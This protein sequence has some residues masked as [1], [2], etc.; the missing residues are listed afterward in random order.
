[1]T[2]KKT[3]LLL[4]IAAFI[5][6]S[7]VTTLSQATYAV[8][9]SDWKA[10]NIIDD[11]L[12]TYA[13]AMNVAQIQTFLN[14]M[15]GT[16]TNGVPGQC[17][18]NGTRTSEYGGGT[19]AEYAAN[20]SLHPRTGAFYPPFTC[21]KD[22][23]EVPKTVPGPGIPAN[24][25]GGKPIPAGAKSAAQLIWDAAQKY[26]ISP[27]VLLVKLGTESAGPL[28][29]D[30]WPTLSQYTYAMGSHCPDSGPDGS[31]NCNTDYSGFSIQISSAASLLRYY[32][33][34]MTAPWW[35]YTKPYQ[36]NSI[37]WNIVE[38]GCG[39][40]NVLVDNKAT[41]ALYTYTPYQPN[42]AAL[43]NMYGNGDSC[44]AY[45]NRNF[46][47]TYNDWFGVT[48]NPSMQFSVIQD[49]NSSTLYLQTS[50]GKYYFSSDAMVQTW[51]LGT[52][53][54]VQVSKAYFDSFTTIG[55][56]SRLIKDDWGNLFLV[57][58]GKLHY[59]RDSSY[60]KLWNLDSSKAVQ[61]RGLLNSML[62]D[63]WVG[64]F[65][66]DINQPDG[67][68]WLIDN[69]TKRAMP[70]GNALYAWGYTSS[71]LTTLTT[72]YLDSIPTSTAVS[73]YASDG[74]TEYL[75]DMNRK[76]S[77]TNTNVENAFVGSQ[78]PVIYAANTLSFLPTMS[79]W[80]F[81]VDASNGRW[82]MLENG[83]K[84][85]I[86]TGKIAEIWGKSSSQGLT[87]VSSRFIAGLQ[88]GGDLQYVVQT[89]NPS[90]YWVIDGAKHY[91]NDSDTANAWTKTGTTTPIYSSQ[92]LSLLSRGADATTTIKAAGSSYFY[93]MDAGIKRY[94]MS[95]NSINGWE[96]AVMNTKNSLV[97][98]IPEGSFLDYI[99]KNAAGQT[100]L[101]MN[102]KSY[103]IDPTYYAEWNIT[104]KTPVVSNATI[105]RYASSG[106]TLQA[107][108]RI[109]NSSYVMLNGNK[110]PI[111]TNY[112][113]YQPASLGQA[114]LPSDYFSTAT[115][116]TY[117][118]RS[119]DTK[120]KSIWLINNGKKYLL[121]SFAIYVSYGYLSR[122]VSLTSLA[123]EALS[124]IP[125]APETPGLFLRRQG[126]Y[127]IKFI[128]F[129]SSLG[130]PNGDTL[131][132]FLGSAPILTVSDSVY[133]SFPLTG[134]VSK[135]VKDDLGRI[136]L[137]EDGK[138]RWITNS[139]AYD[140]YR[141]NPVTYLYGTTMSI[142]PNGTPIN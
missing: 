128:N 43:N 4:I 113:A 61:S 107:Y 74:S 88:D 16:G 89:T 136:Y 134:S 130:F 129:G 86:T 120:D 22:F 38:S 103:L 48:N 139:K 70:N 40:A 39:A 42:Q 54:V 44:S 137:M 109:G 78:S 52:S 105:D 14:N 33:D 67:Q 3:S 90:M 37:Y 81:V 5:S 19:R 73:Q 25:Y 35:P 125:T 60:I 49:P 27:K 46:W 57:D 47:L 32:L 50:A 31:A 11:S 59:I 28:T 6:I 9:A 85:Y 126:S 62:N 15:V 98:I 34:N 20:A 55:P 26:N 82:Y 77:F 76:L 122:N 8:T 79:A 114:T 97:D 21:L 12:F 111:T 96:D 138:K 69:G 80:Q 75:V 135:I 1:M 108:I 36:N 116:A 94:L 142:I 30:D 2:F 24:N 68:V 7:S 115:E 87:G 104:S 110:I 53:T 117:L 100:Y 112:D 56:V 65:V 17:D 99:V 131:S 84:H 101:L 72:D 127:G 83:K 140:V 58:D 66:R 133:N 106:I 123:P 102:S 10:G 13:D 18:T 23:Y 29:S 121:S 45:G 92:S 119:T 118:A 41:A 124:L 63:R 51:G 71:Q 95:P 93:I 64:R 141:N 132:S 91:I